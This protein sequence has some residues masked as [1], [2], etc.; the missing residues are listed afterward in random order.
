MITYYEYPHNH[1]ATFYTK[2]HVPKTRKV[3]QTCQL[4]ILTL[5]ENIG[6]HTDAR[7]L[8]YMGPYIPLHPI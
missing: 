5:Y 3:I 2:I 7:Y 6:T 1:Y 4:F 8:I